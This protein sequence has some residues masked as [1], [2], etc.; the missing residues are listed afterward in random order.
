[1]E[2]IKIEPGKIG[3]FGVG[4][5][6]YWTQF[7]GLKERLNNYLR[8]FEERIK[9]FNA[10]V[11]SAGIIDTPDKAHKAAN[12]F[13]KE[14]V[15][16]IFCNMTTYARSHVLLPIVQKIKAHVVLIGLQPTP[17]MD[18]A[19]ATTFE[20]LANDNSTSLPEFS[21]ALSRAN[22]DFSVVF[23]MLYEDG[24]AWKQI[25]EWAQVATVIHSLSKAHIGLMGHPYEGMLDMYSDPT[26]FH[27]HFPGMEI[28][29][30][31]MSDLKIRIDSITSNEINV[32]KKEIRDFFCFPPPGADP[33]AGPVS[34]EDLDWSARVAVGLDKLISDYSLDGLAYYSRGRCGVI[35]V[36][37]EYERIIPGMIVG[38]SLLTGKGI[39][40]AG[41]GD[42]KNCVAMFIMDR[43]GIGGSFSELHPADFRE[44]FVLIGH[45]GP[46]HIAISDRKPILR[47]LTKLHGKYGY[48]VSVE[49]NVKKGP[50][51]ILSLSQTHDGKFYFVAAEG[52]SLPG[53][54]P[55]TGNTNTRAK[56][57]PDVVTFI[58]KWTEAAPTHH[59]A[60]G[61]GHNISKIKKLSKALRMQL[62]VVSERTD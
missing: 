12:L 9:E 29:M 57:P 55:A 54:I 8:Y 34:E 16:L 45:D 50:I 44:D 30:L 1:M 56:F 28:Q 27:T 33:I 59:H 46:A 47:G 53:P 32:K 24:R 10:Q 42:V 4:H 13:A 21:Y 23:G 5:P 36:G 58:E 52:E 3:I 20:Q 61:I 60:L 11:V 17:G 49:F 43:F 37:T 19:R 18:Y 14:N 35:D 38:N 62:I 15:D 25:K 41:E 31:E 39:P 2:R 26:M 22:I 40:V 51:T 6:R 7:S 48:G